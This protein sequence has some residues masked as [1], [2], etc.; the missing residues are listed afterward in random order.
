MRAK[1]LSLAA[2]LLSAAVLATPGVAQDFPNKPITFLVPFTPGGGADLMARVV[3]EK[4]GE[5]LGQTIVVENRP[6][7]GGT[8][9]AAVAAE[10]APDGYTILET[11]VAH[12]IG[13]SLYKDL[14]YTYP[15]DFAP[16]AGL[17]STGF[18]LSVNPKTPVKTVQEFIDYAKQHDGTLN[19]SSSGNGGPSHLS[20]ELFKSMTGVNLTHIPYKGVSPA[21]ADLVGG[22]VDATFV[23]LPAALPLMEANKIVG[24]GLSTAERSDLAP[25]L[26]TIAESGV[27]GYESATWYGVLAPAGTPAD[28]MKKLSD[29]FMA[30][31]QDPD[32]RAKL[33]GRGFDIANMT[34][35]QFGAYMKSET[36]KWGKIVAATGAAV[37]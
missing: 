28:V 23:A 13:Q 35:E 37:N 34:P 22:Q 17:G 24:L 20:M 4:A 31:R 10:A 3:G 7:A 8:I 6:G 1:F 27:P 14:D 18:V 26:P 5:L 21:V 36:D 32:V 29:A 2:A 9:A 12:A 30:A 19:Y 11:T 15:D 16:V 33:R 25:D